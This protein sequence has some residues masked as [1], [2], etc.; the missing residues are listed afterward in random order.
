MPRVLLLAGIG[1]SILASDACAAGPS[2]PLALAAAR[3]AVDVVRT[4][5]TDHHDPDERDAGGMTPLMWAARSGA[6]DAM[7][8]LLDAGAEPSAR[9]GRNSWTPL[10]HAIHTR[11]V[12]AVRLLLE[13]GVDPNRAGQKMTP[14]I[15]A[16]AD[17]DPAIVELLLQHG[18]DPDAR[19][20]GGS[21]ALTVAVSGGALTDIDRPLF[22][23]CHPAM[24]K[25]LLA[26]RPTLTLPETTA[27]REA[28]WWARF[29]GCA[30]VLA[31]V[32]DGGA[33]LKARA[34]PGS[35]GDGAASASVPTPRRGR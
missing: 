28:L 21:T 5:L 31:L 23:G 1:L 14:L 26:H 20:V 10:F 27:A 9:G 25:A 16:A 2:L 34:A 4:L 13:R 17:P 35:S 6:V 12:A 8:A 3:N 19:G 30:E 33:G 32:G 18:A 29:H 7:R 11:Q 24:V 22:G 15:M